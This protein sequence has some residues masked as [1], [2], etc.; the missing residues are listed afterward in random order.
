VTGRNTGPGKE[1]VV[2][3]GYAG[4]NGC[5]ESWNNEI[6]EGF[7]NKVKG[8]IVMKKHV[9]LFALAEVLLLAFV[10]GSTLVISRLA[11][12][13]LGPFTITVF[14][15]LFAFLVLLP[16]IAHRNLLRRWS[17]RTWLLLLLIGISFYVLVSL[18]QGC[19]ILLGGD[20]LFS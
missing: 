11:L 1:E 5:S 12:N 13:V 6:V 15:Y 20:A 4:A 18:Q 19:G 8:I 17:P 16:F 9:R 2:A 3:Q 14:R 10:L 7:V